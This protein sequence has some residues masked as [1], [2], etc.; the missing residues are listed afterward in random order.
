MWT[1]RGP[2]AVVLKRA[3]VLAARAAERLKTLLQ[4]RS[5]LDATKSGGDTQ[6]GDESAWESLFTPALMHYDIVLKLRR[7]G[8]DSSNVL[9]PVL[10][11]PDYAPFPL[12][13]SRV[14]SLLF[15]LLSVAGE[16]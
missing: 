10:K 5:R 3:Q 13:F 6:L 2:P 9:K 1:R 14:F 4:G 12:L 7:Q 15:S 11:A 8:G 16:D